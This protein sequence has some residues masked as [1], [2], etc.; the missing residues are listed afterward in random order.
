ML[1][2]IPFMPD[3]IIN[4][5]KFTP[6]YYMQNV[7][8]NI[9]NGYINSAGEIV[10]ILILQICWILLFTYIGKKIINRQISKVVVQ[11]G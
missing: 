11:G 2:P 10:K 7:T 5:L 9:Y 8:F 3:I 1:I 6:F 4:I